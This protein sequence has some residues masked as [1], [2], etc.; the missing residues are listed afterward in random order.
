[1]SEQTDC[2]KNDFEERTKLI[3]E[4]LKHLEED[5]LVLKRPSNELSAPS[6]TP[7]PI[8]AVVSREW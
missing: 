3:D 7:V 4:H 6:E 2:L 8:P 5:V 1:M